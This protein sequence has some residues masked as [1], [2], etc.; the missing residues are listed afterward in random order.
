MDGGPCPEEYD[1]VK[2]GL[3]DVLRGQMRQ[4]AANEILSLGAGGGRSIYTYTPTHT[5]THTSYTAAVALSRLLNHH[6]AYGCVHLLVPEL[7]RRRR[8]RVFKI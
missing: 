8:R 4:D 2:Q 5:H 1:R 6:R 3:H 7:R